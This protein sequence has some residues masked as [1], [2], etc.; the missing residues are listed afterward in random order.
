M[1]DSPVN[2]T[3]SVAEDD[4]SRSEFPSRHVSIGSGGMDFDSEVWHCPLL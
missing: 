2:A 1:C 4:G 3:L